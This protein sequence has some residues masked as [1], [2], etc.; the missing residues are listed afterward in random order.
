MKNFRGLFGI[1]TIGL[2]LAT[3]AQAQSFLTN[4]LVAFY[5][6]NGNADDATGHGNDGTVVGATLTADRFG[7]PNRA[8]SFNGVSSMILLP[9]TLFGPTDAAWT[10]SV[11][12]TTNGP[13]HWTEE[14]VFTK[15]CQNGEMTM[16]VVTSG[17]SSGTQVG[18]H[19]PSRWYFA[20]AQLYPITPMQVVAVYEKG[21]SLAPRVPAVDGQEILI[22]EPLQLCPGEFPAQGIFLDV[23][24]QVRPPQPQLLVVVMEQLLEHAASLL[25]GERHLPF[26]GSG[27]N[28]L[29]IP[30]QSDFIAPE[31]IQDGFR[32][33]RVFQRGFER[34]H[35]CV[36][37]VVLHSVVLSFRLN[38]EETDAVGT[39]ASTVALDLDFLC[40]LLIMRPCKSGQPGAK[41]R[42]C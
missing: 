35:H 39:R 4:G 11:W 29:Q 8:Y 9:E 1:F 40:F 32:S 24:G 2:A 16:G 30:N 37:D 28:I 20:S 36:D 42:K 18:V 23:T 14:K 10:V 7:T 33:H 13:G 19:T 21:Q 41:G 15:G 6:F 38:C 5:P 22:D 34:R 31:A 17:S 27:V 26:I 25:V 12:I 3:Q